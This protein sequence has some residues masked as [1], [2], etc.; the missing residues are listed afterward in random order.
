ME[1]KKLNLNDFYH[2]NV[3]YKAINR[4]AVLSYH[5]NLKENNKNINRT[6]IY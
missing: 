1:L 3:C 5:H 4:N 2:K 6:L